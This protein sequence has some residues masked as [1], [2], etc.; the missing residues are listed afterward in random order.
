M[1]SD[2]VTQEGVV[3]IGAGNRLT[4]MVLQKLRN[5]DT[6]GEVKQQVLVQDTTWG[7]H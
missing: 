1:V 6:L 5:Y 7:A 2:I 4:P 3:L